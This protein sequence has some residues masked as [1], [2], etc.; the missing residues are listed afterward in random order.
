MLFNIL[1]RLYI[2]PCGIWFL[3]KLSPCLIK[4]RYKPCGSFQLVDTIRGE[5][6]RQRLMCLR[7]GHCSDRLTKEKIPQ[8]KT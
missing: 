1:K 6:Y 4:H 7:C 5:R 2:I 3:L 8:E